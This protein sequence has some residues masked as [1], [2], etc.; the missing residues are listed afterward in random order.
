MKQ[1]CRQVL[2]CEDMGINRKTFKRWSHDIEDKRKGPLS[3]PSNKLTELEKKEIIKTLTSKEY[4]DLPPCQVVPML[5]D[6]GKY[7]ASESSM[8]RILKNEELLAHRG[9]TKEPSKQRPMPLIAKAPNQIYSWDIT[10]LNT[11]I[12]GQFFYLYMFMDIFSHKIVGF[13]VHENESSVKSSELMTKICESESIKK[14]QVTLHSDNGASMKGAT[15]LATLQ[16]LGITPSFSRPRVSDDNPFSESLFKTLKYSD[17]YPKEGRF[18]SLKE[19]NSWVQNF[20]NWYNGTH[21][22]SGIKFVTP[23]DRHEL[24]DKEILRKRE[25]LYKK[26]R[27]KNPLRWSKK[28]KNWDYIE[29]VSLNHLQKRVKED[30][31]VAS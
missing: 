13:E 14:N 19:A 18:K 25:E 1:G 10:Y 9:K 20:V 16:K 24:K 17:L 3:A 2:A 30:I 31:K 4:V 21:L 5:A 28:T 29:E 15:M 6:K 12:K 7:L 26:A 23:N 8:Y 22:H 27:E 11:S